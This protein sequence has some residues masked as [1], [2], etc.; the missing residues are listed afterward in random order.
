MII[1]DPE[2]MALDAKENR[3]ED[4]EQQK[5]QGGGAR[6]LNGSPKS[7]EYHDCRSPFLA[8]IG[9]GPI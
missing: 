5:R 6:S 8:Q 1:G 2:S 3:T 9:L 4:S 7:S